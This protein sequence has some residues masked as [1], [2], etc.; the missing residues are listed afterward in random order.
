MLA[1]WTYK[2]WG[3]ETKG[4]TKPE[5]IMSTSCHPSVNK[6]GDYMDIKIV[7]VPVDPETL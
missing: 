2:V 1:C 7:T 4:I 6:G 5:I 3:Y